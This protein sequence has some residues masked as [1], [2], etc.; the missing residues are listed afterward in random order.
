MHP[1]ETHCSVLS[2]AV[3]MSKKGK[4]HDGIFVFISRSKTLLMA[5][6]S[7]SDSCSSAGVSPPFPVSYATSEEAKFLT[8]S[9]AASSHNI[10]ALYGIFTVFFQLPIH[11]KATSLSQNCCATGYKWYEK[12]HVFLS[13]S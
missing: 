5:A 9:M 11:H 2:G 4:H 8:V 6:F 10:Q 7:A 13:Q 1:S 3:G 12:G